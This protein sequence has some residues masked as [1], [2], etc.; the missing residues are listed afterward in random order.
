MSLRT[1]LV[2]LALAGTP[3]ALVAGDAPPAQNQN[4]AADPYQQLTPE[5]MNEVAKA[6]DGLEPGGATTVTIGGVAV[7]IAKTS[8]G[9]VGL[10]IGGK[11]ANY[12][13]TDN[14]F[15]VTPV[16]GVARTFKVATSTEY[17]ITRNDR[18]GRKDSFRGNKG[19]RDYWINHAARLSYNWVPWEIT[20]TVVTEVRS[21][22]TAIANNDASP[23]NP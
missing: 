23:F 19:V 13:K 10:S 2:M 21:T 16:G 5:Q 6:A 11:S 7:T 20:R 14:G 8:G 15:T 3:V 22:Q 17:G 9:T 1:C 18:G 4:T 12:K